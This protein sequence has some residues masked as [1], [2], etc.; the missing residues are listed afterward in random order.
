M[1]DLQ[2]RFNSQPLANGSGITGQESKSG[3]MK[4]HNFLLPLNQW[5][6]VFAIN[7]NRQF[8]HIKNLGGN[9][10]YCRLE[11]SLDNQGGS[12]FDTDD[13]NPRFTPTRVCRHEYILNLSNN[14]L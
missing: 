12:T 14:F 1:N 6:Q 9:L 8:L 7:P 5:L 3:S 2:H 13:F 4:V 10:G 11:M